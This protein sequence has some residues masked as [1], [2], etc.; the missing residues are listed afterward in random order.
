MHEQGY[1][2]TDMEQFDRKAFGRKHHE[3]IAEE[4]RYYG[5]QCAV[6][7][8]H[9]G[10]GRNDVKT[11]E[12]CEHKQLVHWKKGTFDQEFSKFR[13]RAV[14]VVVIMDMATFSIV[15]LVGLFLIIATMA[16]VTITY[17]I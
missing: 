11:K 12:E 7:Q 10:G 6:M 16:T 5:D 13:C 3:A 17:L 4:M 8:P 15:C 14:F 2:Q 1:T 9:Q